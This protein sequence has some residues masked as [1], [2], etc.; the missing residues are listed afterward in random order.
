VNDEEDQFHRG[1]P[2]QVRPA[3]DGEPGRRPL[4]GGLFSR[5]T[6]AA[7]VGRMGAV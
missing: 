7:P 2:K 5:F 4:I 3:L 6:A 1:L